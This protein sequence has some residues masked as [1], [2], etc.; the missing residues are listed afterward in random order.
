MS[1]TTQM[2]LRI[3]AA[4]AAICCLLFCV[5][6]GGPASSAS[7]TFSRGTVQMLCYTSLDTQTIRISAVFPV[8]TSP[9]ERML[10]EPWAK[11]FRTYVGQSGNFGSINVTCEQVTSKSAAKDKA[12][13]FRKQGHQVVETTWAYAGG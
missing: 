5:S 8:R 9:P 13:A 1:R 10:E 7:S 3:N 6:C 2:G 12:D 11:D 4:A